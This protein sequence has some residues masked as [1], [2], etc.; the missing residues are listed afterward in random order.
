MGDHPLV[1]SGDQFTSYIN[2]LAQQSP[3]TDTSFHSPM[4]GR[5][6]VVNEFEYG[7]DA[8]F[9]RTSMGQAISLFRVI[10]SSEDPPPSEEEYRQIQAAIHHARDFQERMKRLDKILATPVPHKCYI[11]I[12]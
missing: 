12:I 7:L 2:R 4:E 1:E 11:F 8:P 10:P 6:D 3:A 9:W 5:T